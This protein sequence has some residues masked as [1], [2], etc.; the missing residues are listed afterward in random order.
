MTSTF[1][2][3]LIGLAG[4]LATSCAG[5][6]EVVKP[7]TNG[8]LISRCVNQLDLCARQGYEN[9]AAIGEGSTKQ[10]A[11]NIARN[12]IKRQVLSYLYGTEIIDSSTSIKTSVGRASGT[13]KTNDYTIKHTEVRVAKGTLPKILWEYECSTDSNGNKC[14]VIG[15]IPK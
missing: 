6:Q 14:Y 5:N 4:L 12:S 8:G 1:K 3:G 7:K 11:F 15:Y 2:K 13:P 10:D 9:F